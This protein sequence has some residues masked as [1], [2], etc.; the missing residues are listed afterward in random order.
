M[1]D[2]SRGVWKPAERRIRDLS[3]VHEM[4][5]I[6]NDWFL[7]KDTVDASEM[8]KDYVTPGLPPEE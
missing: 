4:Q 1:A 8:L 2:D 6:L 7:D 5:S 3:V